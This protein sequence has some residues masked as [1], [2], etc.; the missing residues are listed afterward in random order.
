M[1]SLDPTSIFQLS[2]D[3]VSNAPSVLDTRQLSS[4][5]QTIDRSGSDQQRAPGA[6]TGVSAVTS[7]TG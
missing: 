5:W 2:N 3:A 1:P 6:T 7:A 4:S